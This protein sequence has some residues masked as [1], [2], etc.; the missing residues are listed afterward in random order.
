ML[1]ILRN[2]QHVSEDE[3][4]KMCN[5][6]ETPADNSYGRVEFSLGYIK[7]KLQLLFKSC[8][9]S[10]ISSSTSTR[11]RRS[12]LLAL[13]AEFAHDLCDVNIGGHLGLLLLLELAED[14]GA[15]T[16]PSVLCILLQLSITGGGKGEDGWR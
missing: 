13:F 2:M 5:M 6:T 11:R 10:L 9:C 1:L 16:G 3:Q 14:D 8:L 12:R 15:Q 7:N 4:Y